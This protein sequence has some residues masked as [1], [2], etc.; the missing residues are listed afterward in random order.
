VPLTPAMLEIQTAVLDL[1]NFTVKEL[2]HINQTVSY[3]NVI[4]IKQV[5]AVL[6]YHVPVSH[7]LNCEPG[8]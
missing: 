4:H 6:W 2:K 5:T 8:D 7:T 1:M 3:I